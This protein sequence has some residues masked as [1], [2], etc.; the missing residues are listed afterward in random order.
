MF[1]NLGL[2]EVLLLAVVGMLI[3]GPERLP[4]A[5]ADAGRFLKQLRQMARGATDSLKNE[6]GP[7]FADLDVRSLHPRRLLE[8]HVLGDD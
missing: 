2:P 3:F 8:D 1:G 4:K 5:A 6:L 7:E